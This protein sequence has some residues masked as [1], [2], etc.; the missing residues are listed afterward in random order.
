MLVELDDK[1]IERLANKVI[2]LLK[3]LLKP[4]HRGSDQEEVIFD[5]KGLAEYLLIDSS[6]IYKQVSFKAIPFFK[7]GKYIRFKKKEIDRWAES[8]SIKP[9]PPFSWQK[10]KQ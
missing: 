3:P 10:I 9:F 5:V 6:W 1:D 4:S 7:I 2:D 8:K